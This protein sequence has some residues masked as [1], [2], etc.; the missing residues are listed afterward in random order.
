MRA[1]RDSE[2]DVLVSTAVVEVGIDVP[3]ATVILIEG[4]DRF[5]LSQLHQFRGR[6]R[7]SGEQAYCFLLSDNSSPDALERLQIMETVNDGFQLAE[8]DLRL[9]GPGEYFG[10]RQ[11]GLPDLRAARLTDVQLIE[12]TRAEATRLLEEDP[13]L[14]RPEHQALRERLDALWSRVSGD[15]S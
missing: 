9:R 8:E 10:T 2:V 5:G 12:E 15:V 6:V 13:E 1:F 7:R 3:N 11:S 4:A 14:R